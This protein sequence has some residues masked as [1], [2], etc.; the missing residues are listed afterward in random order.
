MKFN[1]ADGVPVS[2]ALNLDQDHHLFELD[3]WKVDFSPLQRWPTAQDLS[4]P[5]TLASGS[6]LTKN[7]SERECPTSPLPSPGFPGKEL[8]G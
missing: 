7:T 5:G 4:G 2:A 6:E 8:W 1:D 3:V